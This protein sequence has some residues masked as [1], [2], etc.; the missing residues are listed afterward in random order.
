MRHQIGTIDEGRLKAVENSW[1]IPMLTH[2]INLVMDT[3][4][5]S[6]IATNYLIL[7]D[8]FQVELS[9]SPRQPH[10]TSVVI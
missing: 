5:R 10:Q 2:K 1:I 8:D 7:P 4:R 3:G 6:L 9:L